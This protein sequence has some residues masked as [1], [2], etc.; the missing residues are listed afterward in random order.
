M[1][2]DHLDGGELLGSAAGAQSRRQRMQAALQ[3]DVRTMG[4]EGD[5]DIGLDPTFLMM[6]DPSDGEVS[7]QVFEGFFDGDELDVALPEGR[8]VAFGEI[9]AQ[10]IA[11]FATPDLGI[12]PGTE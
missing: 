7:L 6:E 12:P 5:E 4:Q 2:I 10:Q 3:R 8:G 9:G 11:P 1:D